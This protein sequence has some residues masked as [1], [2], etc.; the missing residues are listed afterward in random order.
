[1]SAAKKGKLVVISGPSG[2]GK[3]TI[4]REILRRM[5]AVLSV[6]ATTRAKSPQETDGVDYRFITREEFLDRVKKNDFLEY[7]EVFGNLYGTLRD[8]VVQ[9]LNDGNIV[10]LE[11]DVQ[12]GRQ[13]RQNY[14]EVVLIFV[15]PPQSGELERRLSARARD[16]AQ[17]AK[18]RLEAAQREI[19]EAK[20]FYD[21]MV[22]ND[23]LEKAINEVMDIIKKEGITK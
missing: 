3:S 11:I 19:A 8:K 23:N 1:M 16:S 12:G 15:M 18:K 13:V 22:V 14:P 20:E 5:D 10:I 9:A 2:V 17:V 6:S 21:Y 7:A 4:C